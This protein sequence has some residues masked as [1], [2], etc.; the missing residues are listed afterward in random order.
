[1]NFTRRSFIT[2]GPALLPAAALTSST[3]LPPVGPALRPLAPG[4]PDTDYS[5]VI[6]PNGVTLPFRLV[7][8]V[9]VFTSLPRSRS[10]SR[11]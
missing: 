6:T 5:P 7:D 10:G 2:A 4:R 8:G 11:R 9:K 1:M 3:V